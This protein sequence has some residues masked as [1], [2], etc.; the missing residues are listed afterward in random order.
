MKLYICETCGSIL[1]RVADGAHLVCCG[2]SM[3]VLE[4]NTTEAAVEKHIPQAKKE[5]DKLVIEV[6]SV[7]HPMAEEHYIMWIA[8]VGDDIVVKKDL[9]PG[10]APALTV[11]DRGFKE[12]YAYC[13][14]H[15]LWKGEV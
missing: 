3:Q 1:W 9:H 6:G 7:D 4:P 8:A 5:D 10:E 15:G 11:C 13:N 14:L 2:N 12:V